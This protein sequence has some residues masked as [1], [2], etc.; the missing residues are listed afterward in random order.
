MAQW[1]K[2]S[3]TKLDN[4]IQSLDPISDTDRNNSFRLSSEH[5]LPHTSMH[6]QNV[7]KM[8][9]KMLSV[10]ALNLCLSEESF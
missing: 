9:F 1:V 6:A 10:S 8:M 3:A 4:Q 5:T 7:T 2:I